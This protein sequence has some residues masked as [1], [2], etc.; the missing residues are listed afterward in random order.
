[1]GSAASKDTDPISQDWKLSL[2]CFIL[3]QTPAFVVREK[4]TRIPIHFE[5]D[6]RMRSLCPFIFIPVEKTVKLHKRP[7]AWHHNKENWNQRCWVSLYSAMW[8]L[9]DPAKGPGGRPSSPNIFQIMQFSG[10]FKAPSTLEATRETR[11]ATQ[12]NGARSQLC[13]SHVA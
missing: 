4:T 12:Q 3:P 2:L 7:W 9:A 6:M 1:M 8:A 11:R 10:N 5:N 13:A